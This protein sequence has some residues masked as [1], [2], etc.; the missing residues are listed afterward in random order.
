LGFLLL[1]PLYVQPVGDGFP[2]AFEQQAGRIEQASLPWGP[3]FRIAGGV[4]LS[5]DAWTVGLTWTCLPLQKRVATSGSLL[6]L[7]S[8]APQTSS[9]FV[10]S[11]KA[12]TRLHLG[13]VDLALSTFYATS[14][15][16][17]VRPEVGIRFASIRQKFYLTYAGGSLF[18]GDASHVNMKNKFWGVGPEMGI[19][20]TWHLSN[21]WVISGSGSA[22]L[23]YGQFY[24]H[25]SERLEK[26]RT[27][28]MNVVNQWA[29]VAALVGG[30]LGV[31]WETERWSAVFQWENHFFPGQNHWPLLP[32][33]RPVKVLQ[34]WG[35]LGV[36]GLSLALS[37]F[38]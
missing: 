30:T 33:G 28:F 31:G 5:R 26:G 9:S 37:C 4:N 20:L 27:L 25:A 6:P 11:A 3:G 14:P 38:F 29:Q 17:T 18:P 15:G 35:G 8:V 7:W 22:S 32:V 16:L 21:H 2:Y 10:A 12:H 23:V 1:T 13:I 24:V 36:V 19:G 34:D